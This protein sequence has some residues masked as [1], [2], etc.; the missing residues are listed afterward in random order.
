MKVIWGHQMQ[1][2]GH[3]GKCIHF[4]FAQKDKYFW[5]LE[6]LSWLILILLKFTSNPWLLSLPSLAFFSLPKFLFYL[7]HFTSFCF[8]PF[9]N[10]PTPCSLILTS[11]SLVTHYIDKTVF[12]QLSWSS[13]EFHVSYFHSNLDEQQELVTRGEYK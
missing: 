7:S 6:G 13:S 9:P 1:K 2:E 8:P 12:A 4:F 11:I 3:S 10:F 5:K